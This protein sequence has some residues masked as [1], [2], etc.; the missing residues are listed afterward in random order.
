MQNIHNDKA[1]SIT[2]ASMLVIVSEVSGLSASSAV[3]LDCSSTFP[4]LSSTRRT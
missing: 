2:L 1:L 3:G 4:F